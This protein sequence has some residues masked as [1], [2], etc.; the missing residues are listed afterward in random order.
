MNTAIEFQSFPLTENH[1]KILRKATLGNA[2]IEM[3]RDWGTNPEWENNLYFN[4]G[5]LVPHTIQE[6]RNILSQ[7]KI[8][9][10]E[11]VKEVLFLKFIFTKDGQDAFM[12][13]LII[14]KRPD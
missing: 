2:W 9:F 4:F 12:L 14:G 11:L 13:E 3:I 8:D 7:E 10:V 6:I 5:P 1:Q